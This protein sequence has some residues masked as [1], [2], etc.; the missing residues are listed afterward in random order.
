MTIDA[1]NEAKAVSEREW[2][3]TQYSEVAIALDR[4]SDASPSAVG[5]QEQW[6]DYREAL[7]QYPQQ[8]DFPHGVRPSQPV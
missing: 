7:R 8:P 3:N 5:T 6:Q 1:E 4:H 2:R